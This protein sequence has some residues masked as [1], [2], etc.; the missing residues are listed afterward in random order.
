MEKPV[1]SIVLTTYNRPELLRRALKSVQNQ[2]YKDCEIIVVDDC[3]EI[4]VAVPLGVHLI[5]HRT[6]KGLSAARNTGI[7]E[8]SGEYIVC[9]DDDNELL[10]EFLTETVNCL[11]HSDTDAVGVGRIIQYKDFAH[12]VVPKLNKFT[13]ID[14]GWLI[15]KEVFDDIQYDEEL[16]ANE[17]SDFGL[18]FSKKYLKQ[19]INKPLVIAYDTENPRDSL[20]FPN[21]REL[22][23]MRRFFKKNQHEYDDPKERWCLYRLMGRKFYR[24]GFRKKGLMY[25]W[26]GFWGYK[27]FRSF[28]HFFFILFGWTV[29]DKFMTFEEKLA[30]KRR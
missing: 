1:A 19:V 2:T 22:E 10:P 12:T 25:F 23:G 5:R 18:Q 8:A 6:N 17:D 7:K 11:E 4:P 16:R 24:G 9:L 30:A 28:A 15:R 13:A 3:S 27:T 21:E 29:Y 26:K 20:S 14:W